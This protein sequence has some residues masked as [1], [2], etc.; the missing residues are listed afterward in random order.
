MYRL[1]MG[2][3]RMTPTTHA[4]DAHRKA[5][6]RQRMRPKYYWRAGWAQQDNENK[7]HV[8]HNEQAAGIDAGRILRVRIGLQV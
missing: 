6:K 2:L 7:I 1:S 5:D 4:F 3:V 8:M